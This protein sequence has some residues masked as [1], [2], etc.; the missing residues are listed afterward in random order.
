MVSIP[1]LSTELINK[2]I[3][4]NKIKLPIKYLNMNLGA[5]I[6]QNLSVETKHT[7]GCE[8]VDSM[9]FQLLIKDTLLKARNLNAIPVQTPK[10]EKYVNKS[11]SGI[12]KCR[13]P[14]KINKKIHAAQ[15]KK[16]KFA[17]RLSVNTA[18][19]FVNKAHVNKSIT[20]VGNV[21]T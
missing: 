11:T 19:P 6:S 21:S 1:L 13:T 18:S 15:V 12:I 20:I 3:A 10:Q 4:T 17:Q 14:P 5:Q 2:F 9:I 8:I 7:K 16:L